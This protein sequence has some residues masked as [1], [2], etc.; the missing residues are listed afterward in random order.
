MMKSHPSFAAGAPYRLRAMA[1][2]EKFRGR[3]FGGIL[4]RQGVEELRSRRCDLLW[5]DARVRAIPFYERM[6]FQV[7]GEF[8]NTANGPHKTMY[9]HLIPR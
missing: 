5:F 7:S 6:G 9:K 8:F 3:G 4:L 1:S 2:D